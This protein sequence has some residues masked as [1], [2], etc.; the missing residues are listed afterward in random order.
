VS[1]P[2]RHLR[3]LVSKARFIFTVSAFFYLCQVFDAGAGWFIDQKK[4]HASVHSMFS[5][6]DCHEDVDGRKLHPNPEDMVKKRTDFFVVDQCLI[7][8]DDVLDRLEQGMH[9]S[10]TIRTPDSYQKC[11]QCHEPHYQRPIREEQGLFDPDLPRHEQCG[12]CHKQ[13]A[14]LPPLSQEDEVCMTC[15]RSIESGEEKRLRSICFHCHAREG[16]PAQKMTGK[17]VA[18]IEVDGYEAT[19]HANIACTDCHPQAVRFN[20]GQQVPSECTHCHHRHDEKVAHEL[21]G[22]VT[23]GACHLGGVEPIR[24][25]RTR[26]IVWKRGYE[27]GAPSE[28][29]DMTAHY[30]EVACRNCHVS[31]NRIGAAA[32]ILPPKSIICMLCHA[33]TFSIGDATTILALLIFAAG[34]VMMLAYVFTGSGE[35]RSAGFAGKGG[36]EGRVAKAVLLDVLLQRRLYLQSRK[37]WLI[38]GLIFYAFAFRFWWGLVGLVGSLWNP[39]GSWV[40]SMLDKNNPL[41]G[42]LF[43]LTGIMIIMGIVMA[44]IRG[45]EKRLSE[46]AVS[47]GQDRLALTLI[48][49]IVLVGFLLQGM[50]IAMTGYPP[51]SS[52]SFVGYPISI[53]WAGATWTGVYGYVWYLHAVLT[54]AFIAYIPFS[55][56]AHIIIA[57]VVLAMNA[58]KKH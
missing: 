25:E 17:K 10:L 6:Q 8:H 38:H 41:T 32:M 28:I 7:C 57:P 13:E 54:G 23:C 49:A 21:H 42:F 39:S 4:F 5:C 1:A 48:A 36:A 9:G 20:H 22:L 34:M 56:L 31:E 19:P 26:Q 37:R 52:W 27:P 40:W 45:A 50:R 15:H 53:F 14:A 16:T 18:L 11:Y 29:H 51:G 12:V 2:T 55:R 44:L 3:P 47:P 35:N 30:D 33:A 58:A 24:E 46:V 43:D